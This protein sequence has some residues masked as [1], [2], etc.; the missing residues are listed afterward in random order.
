MKI[1]AWPRHDPYHA[2]A[3]VEVVHPGPAY[4]LS[5]DGMEEMGIHKW[6]VGQELRPGPQIR[7][8]GPIVLAPDVIMATLGALGIGGSL[9]V[10]NP[11]VSMV[12][13]MTGS[14]AFAVG[15]HG[16]LMKLT[17]GAVSAATT[18]F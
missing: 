5:V 16:A 15:L 11:T 14:M 3:T 18:R 7:E 4:G 6:Y 9:L 2:N 12:T 17:Q 8:I 1:V 13:L 10:K